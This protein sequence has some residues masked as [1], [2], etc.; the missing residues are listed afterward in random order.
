MVVIA[1]LAIGIV[2]LGS[3]VL[4]QQAQL[5][6]LSRT[7]AEQSSELAHPSEGLVLSNFSVTRANATAKPLMF[8]VIHNNGTVPASSGSYLAMVYGKNNSIQSCYDGTGNYFPIFSNESAMVFAP[9]KCGGIGDVV[10]L[11]VQA[12]FLASGGS[13]AKTFTVKTAIGQ[14]QAI[15]VSTVV[16][17]QLGIK[18]WVVPEFFS[19]GVV[20]TWDLTITNE[21]SAPIVAVHATLSSGN[22][23][24]AADSGCVI[25]SGNIYGVSSIAPLTATASCSDDN[26]L[27]TGAG[28]FSMGQQLNVTVTVRYLNGTSSSASTTAVVEPPYAI[29]Q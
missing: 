11:T 19:S 12:E 5:G 28:P 23:T 15:P 9:L 24:L 25:L 7:I 3:V 17:K 10:V 8:L 26:N 21:G 14:S 29:F 1:V 4:Y 20:Y 6:S 22:D 16:I 13:T 18:T 27:K 2:A